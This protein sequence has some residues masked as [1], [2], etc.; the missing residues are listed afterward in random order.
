MTDR[1]LMQMAL[2]AFE[3]VADDAEE[4]HK[5]VS[6]IKALRAALANEFNPDWDRVEALQE[7]LREHMA[8]IQRLRAALAQPE[9]EPVAWMEIEKYID[10]DNLWDSRKILRDY[11]NGL[12][13]P[14]YTTPPQREVYCGCGDEI[15]AGDGARCG[16]CV[17]VKY[18]EKKWISL[19]DE[20]HMQIAIDCGCLGADWVFYGAAVERKLKEKNAP[21]L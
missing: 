8:E 20:E 10:E 21:N 9:Q 16:T 13:E 12:G 6:A 5:T 14:L 1:E 4:S 3:D 18:K 11:D 7:S 2:D 15:V 17:A 19:T